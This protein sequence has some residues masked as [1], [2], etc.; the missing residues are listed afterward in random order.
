MS[1]PPKFAGTMLIFLPL[2]A[3]C[4]SPSDNEVAACVRKKIGDGQASRLSSDAKPR[5]E[6]APSGP[7]GCDSYV[8]VLGAKV[9]DQQIDGKSAR[10]VANVRWKAKGLFG[11][12][13]LT[14]STCLVSSADPASYYQIDEVT[15]SK[16]EVELEK[17]ASGWKCKE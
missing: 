14:A 5:V 2:L 13:S 6:G 11:K 12:S 10:V 8:E 1:I 4:N 17:W 9:A 16:V 7:I 3:G 15:E